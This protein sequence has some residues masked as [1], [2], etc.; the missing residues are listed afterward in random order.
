[1]VR[2]RITNN[3]PFSSP[4]TLMTSLY[5]AL[6]TPTGKVI[7]SS[8][9][10]SRPPTPQYSGLKQRGNNKPIFWSIHWYLLISFVDKYASLTAQIARQHKYLPGMY[11]HRSVVQ[12]SE[13][14]WEFGGYCLEERVV[15]CQYGSSH[16]LSLAW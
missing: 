11:Y 6:T 12:G 7:T 8:S 1:M 16:H 4:P 2:R 5:P 14:S 10:I 15:E 9:Q 3:I 13:I